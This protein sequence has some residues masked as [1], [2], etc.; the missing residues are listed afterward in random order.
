MSHHTIIEGLH[1]RTS[2]HH[3]TGKCYFCGK[4]TAKK[5]YTSTQFGF[6]FPTESFLSQFV[7]QFPEIR[8][9]KIHPFQN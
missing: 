8:Y 4:Y 1:A 5:H 3:Y 7:S 6:S 2:Q 9:A